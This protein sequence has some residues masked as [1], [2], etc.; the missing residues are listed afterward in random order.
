M[1]RLAYLIVAG[2]GAATA[3][4]IGWILGYVLAPMEDE[5]ASS[6][7]KCP[8]CGIWTDHEPLRRRGEQV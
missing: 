6:R 8:S 3:F 7:T 2:A 4:T 5:P 1:A